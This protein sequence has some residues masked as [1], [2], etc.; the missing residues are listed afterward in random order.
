MRV[1]GGA[2]VSPAWKA[3]KREVDIIENELVRLAAELAW[4]KFNKER[5]AIDDENARNKFLFHANAQ[6]RASVAFL[7]ELS[8]PAPSSQGLLS[9]GA[10]HDSSS[11]RADRLDFDNI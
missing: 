9:P 3:A 8:R 6:M 2:E 11:A 10:M 7:R 1:Y 4:L 5:M